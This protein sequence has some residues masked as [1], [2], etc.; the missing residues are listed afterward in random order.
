MFLEN[1]CF[2]YLQPVCWNG[3]DARWAEV[4]LVLFVPVVKRSECYGSV[5][6]EYAFVVEMQTSVVVSSKR[7]SV[8]EC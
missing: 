2:S 6:M 8:C 1:R 5:V 4:G 3:S 7:R